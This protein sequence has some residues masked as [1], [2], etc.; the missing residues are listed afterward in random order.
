[1][2][3]LK[4]SYEFPPIGGGG[5]R[6]VHGLARQ[7]VQSGHSVDLVTMGF[8]NLP[9]FEIVD[10]INVHRIPC[11]RRSESICRPY[12]MATYLLSAT[13]KI[14]RLVKE[15]NYDINHTHFIFP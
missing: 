1:M 13:P 3:I 4:I 2:K 14:N 9:K 10:G 12:E 15:N 7:L 11:I 8:R 6:V 5:S